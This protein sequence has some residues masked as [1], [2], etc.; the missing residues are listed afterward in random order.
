[1]GSER[2]GGCPCPQNIGHTHTQ[3]HTHPRPMHIHTPPSPQM[4]T[5]TRDTLPPPR[6]DLGP[7]IPQRDLV[8]GIPPPKLP[9]ARD[10]TPPVNRHIPVK[11]LPSRNCF[12]V[13]YSLIVNKPL[14]LC[15]Y[16]WLWFIPWCTRVTFVRLFTSAIR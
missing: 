9:D 16:S 7:D 15:L 11:I 5:G 8:S 10:V 4:G 6:R 1:M 2:C 3:G 12:R 14:F 13:R